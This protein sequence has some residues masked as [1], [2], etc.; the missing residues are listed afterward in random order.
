MTSTEKLASL[1]AD[2][3]AKLAEIASIKEQLDRA[4][5]R[6]KEKH[7]SDHKEWLFRTKRALRHK[8]IDLL[9]INQELGLLNREIKQEKH[10]INESGRNAYSERF[11]AVARNVLDQETFLAIAAAAALS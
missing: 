10:A 8:N 3:H 4:E 7:G 9:K 2:Q 6:P 5:D 11:I 1:Y